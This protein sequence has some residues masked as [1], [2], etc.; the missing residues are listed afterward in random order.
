MMKGGRFPLAPAPAK[1]PKVGEPAEPPKG[2]VFRTPPL[3]GS[4]AAP[5][6]P[7]C[8]FY[9]FFFYNKKTRLS[10]QKII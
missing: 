5:Q 10:I 1:V 3:R 2:R 8:Y 9:S 7:A 4:D 6:R